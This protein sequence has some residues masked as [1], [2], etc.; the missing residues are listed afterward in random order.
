MFQIRQSVYNDVSSTMFDAY[1]QRLTAKL[2]DPEFAGAHAR[3]FPDGAPESRLRETALRL[4]EEAEAFGFV[5]EGDVTPFVL[6][7]FALDELC[8]DNGLEEWI[9]TL[10]HTPDIPA[11]DRMDAIGEL[12]PEP[13]R[14]LV[15]DT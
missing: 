4:V 5:C 8:R 12:F 13:Q 15:F 1:L 14:L 6:I 10:L 7:R 2:L 11:E 9:R 3:W